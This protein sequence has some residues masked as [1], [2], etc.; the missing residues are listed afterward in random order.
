ML[1]LMLLRFGLKG[2]RLYYCLQENDGDLSGIDTQQFV[3]E[4]GLRVL[5]SLQKVSNQY[6]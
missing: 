2:I 6:A 1:H 4:F 5:T 3:F